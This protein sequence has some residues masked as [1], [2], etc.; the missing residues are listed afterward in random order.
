MKYKLGLVLAAVFVIG[1]ALAVFGADDAKQ[2]PSCKYCGMDREK[3]AH[4]RVLVHYDDGKG[5][6]FCSI[7][8]AV[9]DLAV[10]IDRAPGSVGVGNYKTKGLI[11]AEKAFWVIGGSKPG[12]MSGRAKWA[13]KTEDEA[14]AFI[15]EFGGEAATFE[16]AVKAAYEDMYQDTRAIRERRAMKRK[17]MEAN[18]GMEHGHK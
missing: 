5:E 14:A 15:K 18:K 10:N 7:H 3:F 16:S 1:W 8:C 13:F 17:A 9:V 4:S 11:D 6:G 2:Y 12:V